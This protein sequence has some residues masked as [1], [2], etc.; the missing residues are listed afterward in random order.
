MSAQAQAHDTPQDERQQQTRETAGPVLA[1]GILPRAGGAVQQDLNDRAGANGGVPVDMEVQGAMVTASDI[2]RTGDDPPETVAPAATLEQAGRRSARTIP[3]VASGPLQANGTPSRQSMLSTEFLTPRSAAAVHAQG[4]W[5]GQMEWPRWMMR[6]G[7]YV[8]QATAADLIPSPLSSTSSPP[9]GAVFTLRSPPR[10]RPTGRPVTPPSSSSIP[11]E[12]IQQEVQRQLGDLLGRLDEAERHN[13]QLLQDLGNAREEA[14]RW[15]VGSLQERPSRLLSS[16]L[17]VLDVS[18]RALPNHEMSD[19]SYRSLTQYPKVLPSRE[20]LDIN[21]RVFC[22]D[23]LEEQEDVLNLHHLPGSLKDWVEVASSTMADISEQSGAWWRA[24]MMVVESAYV[25]WLNATPLERLAVGP[26]GTEELVGTRWTRLNARVSSLLLV[27]MGPELR[28]DMISQR[29][30]QNTPKMMF[31]VFTWYQP[32]GSAER[33]EVLRRLQV[34]YEFVEAAGNLRDILKEVREWPRWLARCTKMGMMPPDPS[35]MA[36]GL[37]H[38]SEKHLQGSSDSAFRTAML[39]TTLRL[40]GQPTLDQVRSYQRHIQA[41]LEN[42][43]AAQP[44]SAST[45]TAPRAR[46]VE[47]TTTSPTTSPKGATRTKDKGAEP[48]K[49]FAKPTGCKRGDRCT[50][51]HNMQHMDR[52]VRARKC[53]KCGSESHRARE[54]GVGKQPPRHH[55]S[56]RSVHA[57]YGIVNFA[58]QQVIQSQSTAATTAVDEE[59]W[60]AADEVVVQLAGNKS[61]TMSSASTAA[62]AG[63]QTIVPLGELVKTLGY[64]LNWL[65]DRKRER[66]ENEMTLTTDRVAMA[67]VPGECL[68]GLAQGGILEAGWRNM[69]NIDYL[70]RPQKRHLWA[71]KKWIVH[72]CAGNPGHYQF[73]QLDEGS[74]AVLELDVDRCRGHD[75][76]RD[77]TWR[78]LLWGALTGRIDGVVGGPPGRTAQLL[79]IK[80]GT[81]KDIKALGVITRM[82]WLYAVSTAARESGAGGLNRKRPVAFAL[83]HPAESVRGSQSIWRTSLWAQFRAEMEFSEVTFDQGLMGAE[84]RN[85]TTL[86]TNVY[87]LMGMDGITSEAEEDQQQSRGSDNGVWSP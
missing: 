57:V 84:H 3:D 20:M 82:M 71:A 81:T 40:D 50:Y 45:T 74:T 24:V 87:Y 7:S 47:V 73:F 11:A 9:G 1:N 26:E 67:D 65:E 56:S 15:R 34:P 31:R 22:V 33:E 85:I 61:L 19:I 80:K 62:T 52:E 68:S 13:A 27:A 69:K 86:G 49:Y 66:L 14:E 64:T 54:C 16:L 44:V 29:I 42:L 76:L 59:E 4:S 18:Y 38:L 2:R 25:R 58:A 43:V 72:L 36:R 70:T 30:T 8:G 78:L 48:C 41:E 37:C 39:R 55:N 77:P 12:A 6:L 46:A 28:S 21:Y 51:S 10:Q 32:G 83:E 53:L 5:L 63:G 60:T 75:V 17:E 35:V 79:N 23:F